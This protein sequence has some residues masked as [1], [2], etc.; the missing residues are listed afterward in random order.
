[1]NKTQAIQKILPLSPMQEGVLYH[2][3]LDSASLFYL[4]HITFEIEGE[5]DLKI[6]E[7]SYNEL[8]KKFENYRTIYIYEK[9]KKP[10]QVVLKERTF[11]ISFE[12]IECF[13]E[14]E[15][16]QIIEK[17]KIEDRAK[18]FNLARDL[19]IRVKVFKMGS[20]LHKIVWSDHLITRD[21]WSFG[22]IAKDFFNIYKSLK[23][24]QSLYIEEVYP[25]SDYIEWLERQD[26]ENAL[27]YWKEYLKGY[28]SQVSLPIL[29]CAYAS[30][31]YEYDEVSFTL[32]ENI[33]GGLQDLAKTNKVT[34][35][36]V[37]QSIWGILLQRYNNCDDVVFGAVVSGRPPEINGIEK[38]VGLFINTMPVR[39]SSTG[40]IPFSEMLCKV[41]S[42]AYNSTQY[43]YL[44]LAEVQSASELKQ[45]L[46]DHIVI[47]ENYPLPDEI[48]NL[49]HEKGVGFVISHAKVEERTSYGFNMEVTIGKELKVRMYYNAN[50]YDRTFLKAIKGHFK[51]VAES[52]IHNCSIPVSEIDILTEDEKSRILHG[53][54]DTHTYFP[55]N[56]TINEVFKRKVMEKP[57]GIAVIYKD[58]TL[59]YAELD[60]KVNQLSACLREKGVKRG[61]IVGI[62]VER[63]LEMIIGILGILRAGAAYLPIDPYYPKDRVKY[64]LED[65]RAVKLLVAYNNTEGRI[66]ESVEEIN[67]E[68][69]RLFSGEKVDVEEI[70]T[71]GDLAYVIYTSG[72]T[73][74]PKGVMIEHS[75]V[76][77]ILF[78]LEKE[79][80]MAD[81]DVYMLKTSYTFDVSV[82]ELFGWFFGDG[83]LAILEQ[84]MEKE[85]SAILKAIEENEITHINFVPSMFNVF[86]KFI[87][88]EMAQTIDRLKYVFVAGEA[89]SAETVI[90]FRKLTSRVRLENLYGP[91]ES[92]IYATGFS[93]GNFK[94]GT[95]VPIGKPLQNIQVYIVDNYNNLQPVGVVGELVLGGKGLARGYLNRPELTVE[96]FV[97]NPFA[98]SKSKEVKSQLMYRTGDLARW[99][100][101][102]NIEFL[103]RKD[104][105]VKIRGFRIELGEIESLLLKHDHVKETV[106]TAREDLDGNMYL[107]AHVVPY[108]NFKETD[109]RQ[110]LLNFLPEYMVPSKFVY[111]DRMPLT[112]SGKID[113]KSL[114]QLWSMTCP[115]IEYE[116][117]RNEIEE[118]LVSIWQE[119]L[120]IDRIGINHNFYELGGHSLKAIQIISQA[121]N[122]GITLNVSSIFRYQ[123]IK[124]LMDSMALRKI[125]KS[126]LI[127]RAE[128]VEEELSRKLNIKGKMQVHS[129]EDKACYVLYVDME[130]P[131]DDEKLMNFIKKSMAMEIYPHYIISMKEETVLDGDGKEFLRAM[132]LIDGDEGEICRDLMNSVSEAMHRYSASII[133]SKAL[134]ERDVSPA[135]MYH[136]KYSEFEMVGTIIRFDRYLD[137]EILK[138][139]VI[140]LLRTQELMR[141]VLEMRGGKYIW[142]ELECPEEI[143]IPYIDIS[144]YGLP[145]QKIILNKV[146][147]E[148]Y[149]KKYSS[150]DYLPYRILL[151][152]KNLRDYLLIL[153][154]SHIAYDIMT[155]EILKSKIFEYYD[156][157]LNKEVVPCLEAGGYWDYI[158]QIGK[159][160]QGLTDNA[161][162]EVFE[163][164]E[165]KQY[166][167]TVNSISL[168]KNTGKSTRVKLEIE[169]SRLCHEWE[170]NRIW[171]RSFEIF[172][173]FCK[174][175]FGIHKT[176]LWVVNYGRHYEDKTYFDTV[177]EFIDILPILADECKYGS[178]D[179]VAG[180]IQ[181]KIKKACMYNVNF[182]YL[183]LEE[184]SKD[185]YPK[186]VEFIRKYIE[187][188][189]IL[190]NFQGEFDEKDLDN[191]RNLIHTNMV[192]GNIR[193]IMLEVKYSR[194]TV[195]FD[196][197][198]PFEESEE[199][200]EGILWEAINKKYKGGV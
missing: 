77:N 57:H 80:P 102:G 26:K 69:N 99:L 170:T 48:R 62:M 199:M 115:A 179:G 189:L 194:N 66:S 159:G 181:G 161:L 125:E 144:G 61:D 151:V 84:G 146:M 5:L 65:S 192:F 186:T 16:E 56:M 14:E 85:P 153:P 173:G 200:L 19:M 50:L 108:E 7:R 42:A 132:D 87:K 3:L 145:L 166:M 106:V 134:G 39:I 169:L 34:L 155:S 135:Q 81:G 22:I 158:K 195:R 8:I 12:N 97:S 101:D 107:C 49:S 55:E 172:A 54:N 197:I 24:G 43:E 147:S 184:K 32:D 116:E 59:T 46:F 154:F 52:V 126:G 72:S 139:S 162:V 128:E 95:S 1:M 188:P 117:P 187:Q 10:K 71:P 137:M 112:A 150:E 11:K 45:G 103:G 68:D 92:T 176:P 185:L 143:Q 149:F 25:F 156:K 89:I 178:G 63:S 93:L 183:L 9:V 165:L 44:T 23:N 177:G 124:G 75:S 164:E 83:R 30:D 105:Q 119:V 51:K 196:L 190:F 18:G 78:A 82:T 79:Y 40:D 88:K 104:C 136:L 96:K 15:R 160:P 76:V 121:A 168:N 109:L 4:E 2:T 122:F 129:V 70:N 141:S 131:S 38:M 58:N 37:F 175:Y 73:G 91:T 182:L 74:Q 198:L 41:Q 53:F 193:R 33:T 31:G 113:R 123:T 100:T 13:E 21:G 90:N 29:P 6:L 133:T 152:K 142:K 140:H 67:L 47:F 120:G 148:F 17:Y 167:D 163:L 20:K 174:D 111:M 180:Y 157:Y 127:L 60:I 171:D 94:H 64:M 36:V 191:V 35:N 110:Y 86:V 114:P 118:K 138:K 98:N 130:N 27:R 28:R